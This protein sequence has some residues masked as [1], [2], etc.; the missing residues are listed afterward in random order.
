M[1]EKQIQGKCKTIKIWTSLSSKQQNTNVK[2]KKLYYI[3]TYLKILSE[4]NLIAH[5]SPNR[6]FIVFLRGATVQVKYKRTEKK[7]ET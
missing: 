5:N 1:G 3:Y 4:L 7:E 2:K 6:D